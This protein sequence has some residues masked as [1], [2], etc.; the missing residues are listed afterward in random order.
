MR[1]PGVSVEELDR[2]VRRRAEDRLIYMLAYPNCAHRHTAVGDSF[3]HG[4]DVGSHVEALCGKILAGAA[5]PADHFIEDQQNLMRRAYLAQPLK[6]TYRRHIDACG[7]SNRF[8]DT[9]RDV[10][11]SVQVDHALQILCEFSTFWRLAESTAILLEQGMPHV[12]N[13]QGHS[14]KSPAIAYHARERRSA[15]IHAMIRPLAGDKHCP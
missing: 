8:Y 7:S 15:N 12:N 3:G 11:C 13:R 14:L 4:N 2:L 10:F 6:V 5:K 1:R 9:R